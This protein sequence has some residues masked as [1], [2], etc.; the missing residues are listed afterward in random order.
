MRLTKNDKIFNKIIWL[1]VIILFCSFKINRTTKVPLDNEFVLEAKKGKLFFNGVQYVS[2]GD[3]K[4]NV[5]QIH[6]EPYS[7]AEDPNGT[8]LYYKKDCVNI[9]F[10]N[11]DEVCNFYV[12]FLE[13]ENGNYIQTKITKFC[14]ED[15]VFTSM[16]TYFDVYEYFIKHSISFTT[17]ETGSEYLI[18]AEITDGFKLWIHFFKEENSKIKDIHYY[19]R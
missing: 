11:S 4:Q 2:F 1:V 13:K 7:E 15:L 10:N 6:G 3:K 8:S 19:S 9:S 18:D 16:D 5:I 17:K 12:L 14:I